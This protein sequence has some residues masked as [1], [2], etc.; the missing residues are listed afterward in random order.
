MRL[1]DFFR[2]VIGRGDVVSVTGCGGKTS[3]IWTLAEWKRRQK[4]LV[5]TTTHTQK[6]EGVGQVNFFFDESA[7][8]N[9]KPSNGITLAG[10]LNGRGASIRSFSVS[11]L[12]SM[13]PL[14]DHVFIE[15]D[16]SRALPLKAWAHY[17]PVITEST[18]VTIGILPLWPLGKPVSQGFIHRLS[19]FI[20]LSGAKEGGGIDLEHYVPVISGRSVDGVDMDAALEQAAGG[21]AHSLFRIAKGKKILFFNQIEDKRQ[22][23][24]ARRLVA[25][26]PS[27]F[28]RDL[29][30]VIAGSIRDDRV[31]QL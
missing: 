10:N 19:L 2:S 5:T 29:L 12:E 27:G 20:A 24:N 1:T 11:V 15:A 23:E 25:M 17:E 13:I 3:L 8:Q 21:G 28:R 31:E 4:T 18:T 26:L 7:S 22:F 14:F 6:P 9:F 16:G 30:A